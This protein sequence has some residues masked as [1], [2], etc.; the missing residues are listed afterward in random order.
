MR[1]FTTWALAGFLVTFAILTGFSIGFLVAPFAAV[2]VGLAWRQT[3]R[4]V[5]VSGMVLGA[6][7]TLVFIGLLNVD[8]DPV[9]W[10]VAGTALAA[11]SVGL[12]RALRR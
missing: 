2:A 11:I 3:A 5:E 8:H 10:L 4:D 9:P 7:M 6:G 12:Y 1:G